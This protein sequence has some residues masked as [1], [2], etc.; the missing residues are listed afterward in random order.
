MH[1][2]YFFHIPELDL[3]TEQQSILHKRFL[4]SKIT[5][6]GYNK[7]THS[8]LNTFHTNINVLE[9]IYSE[10]TIKQIEDLCGG[11]PE[12]KFGRSSSYEFLMTKG[13]VQMHRDPV[14]LAVLTIPIKHDDSK[15]EFWNDQETEIVSEL[16]Y[17][18]KTYIMRTKT[19]HSVSSSK[20]TRVFWQGSI[21]TR[22]F[23]QLQNDYLDGRLFK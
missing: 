12:D 8:Y 16:D 23:D 2:E 5:H 20:K 13:K 7:N 19:P 10:S 6:K 4:V 21:F 11:F 22:D 1:K 3:N 15:L 17:S 18:D 9:G 14:R